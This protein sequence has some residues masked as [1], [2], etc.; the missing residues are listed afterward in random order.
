MAIKW[1]EPI[2]VKIRMSKKRKYRTLT[3]SLALI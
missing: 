3:E 1:V 2:L